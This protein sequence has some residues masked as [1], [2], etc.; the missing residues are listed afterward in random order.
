VVERARAAKRRRARRRCLLSRPPG[1]SVGDNYDDVLKRYFARV[2]HRDTEAYTLWESRQDPQAF[3][4]AFVEMMG[5]VA[6]PDRPDPFK[7]TRAT[8]STS[9]RRRTRKH[10]ARRTLRA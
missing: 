3:L 1:A 8:A 4:D 5:P 9:P 2:R 7:V 6:A 10:R